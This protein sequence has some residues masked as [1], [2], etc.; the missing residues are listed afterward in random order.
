MEVDGVR[1]ELVV[2]EL[3]PAPRDRSNFTGSHTVI[4]SSSQIS[5]KRARPAR[6]RHRRSNCWACLLLRLRR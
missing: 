4:A 6:F 1:P 3:L 2:N 5:L